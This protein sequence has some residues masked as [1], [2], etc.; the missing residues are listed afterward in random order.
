LIS[1]VRYALDYGKVSKQRERYDVV[2]GV[3]GAGK[4]YTMMQE[5]SKKS[6][7]DLSKVL[8]LANTVGAVTSAREKGRKFGM[9]LGFLKH[10]VITLDSYL[11]H[12]K[13]PTEILCVDE[14]PM[15][16]IAKVDAVVSISGAEEVKLYGE[17]QQIPYDPFCAEFLV[18]HSKLGRTVLRSRVKFLPMTHR[19]RADVCAMWLDRYPAFYPCD[20]CNVEGK[21]RPSL[22]VRRIKTLAE[23]NVGERTRV[24]TYKQDEKEEVWSALSFQ[25]DLVELKGVDN[26]GLSTVHEGQGKTHEN[27]LTLR[28]NEVYDKNASERNPSLYNRLNYVLTDT[29][30]HTHSYTYM[31]LCEENDLVMKRVAMSRD[32]ERLKLVSEKKGIAYVDV[33]DML[34]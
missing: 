3:P 9:D 21:G 1:A 11:M 8:V 12:G 15:C 32:V 18:Q 28:V 34:C 26:G 30:R 22:F 31:T 27:V 5:L 33:L 14:F 10:R 29:T 2:L 19:N 16:H 4:T 23:V 25:R 6:V 24:H 20:C 7:N 17:A 13:F